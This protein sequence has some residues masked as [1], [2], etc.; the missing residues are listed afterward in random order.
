MFVAGYVL[1]DV[2]TGRWTHALRLALV[3]LLPFVAWQ[4]CLK[5]W[6]GSFGVGPG[7]A[8]NSSFEIIPFNGFWRVAYDPSGSIPAFLLLSLYTVSAVI[9]PS[10]WA[11]IVTLRDLRRGHYH[12]YTCLLLANAALM[13]VVPFSTYREPL[14]LLRYSPLWLA[15]SIYLVA[16]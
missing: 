12:V 14:G 11:I 10:M 15:L 5:L 9:A 16:G 6:L 3:A 4:V 1:Y 8:G 7:G 2:L 13:A